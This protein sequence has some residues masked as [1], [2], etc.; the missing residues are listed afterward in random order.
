VSKSAFPAKF[1]LGTEEMAA[2]LGIH[3][4]T[5]LRLRRQPFS[6]FVEG[7]HFR[8]GGLSTRSPLQ[9]EPVSTDAAF[10]GF[11]RIDPTQ[12]ET[13]SRGDG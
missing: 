4:K 6:P 11:R 13:F 8:R 9:W 7:Q 5:L 12:V 1:W 10:T 3:P 2:Q